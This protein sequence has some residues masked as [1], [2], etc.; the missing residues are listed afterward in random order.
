MLDVMTFAELKF[1][2]EMWVKGEFDVGQ[3]Y[4]KQVAIVCI[5]KYYFLLY[6]I[7]SNVFAFH[8]KV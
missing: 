2:L 8:F 6:N 3:N 5:L 7:C 1:S 4:I